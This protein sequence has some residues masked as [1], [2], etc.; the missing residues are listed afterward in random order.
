M[1]K[2]SR[3]CWYDLMFCW[4][5]SFLDKFPSPNFFQLLAL[6]IILIFAIRNICTNV[7][8]T[9]HVLWCDQGLWWKFFWEKIPRPNFWK[10]CVCFSLIRENKAWL[11]SNTFRGQIMWSMFLFIP[12]IFLIIQSITCIWINDLYLSTD[13]FILK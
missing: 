5:I 1:S 13:V 2:D 6:K 12:N 10:C 11:N 3:S 7:I 9:I 4:Q 8:R